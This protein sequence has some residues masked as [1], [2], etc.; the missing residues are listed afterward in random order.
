MILLFKVIIVTLTFS[1]PLTLA[2]KD[3]EHYSSFLP[4]FESQFIKYT[5]DHSLSLRYSRSQGYY[6]VATREIAMGSPVYEVP[7]KYLIT[8]YD[9]FEEKQQWYEMIREAQRL[10]PGVLG[11]VSFVS[12]ALMA[13]M[14]MVQ[15][16]YHREDPFQRGT[17]HG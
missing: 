4:F 16:K 1:P 15:Y 13:V 12:K 2:I 5:N 10:N 7:C 14:L 17:K 8:T 11:E 9:A 3:E 6:T